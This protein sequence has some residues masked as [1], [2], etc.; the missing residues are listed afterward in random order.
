MTLTDVRLEH[1]TIIQH[2]DDIIS[3]WD[4]EDLVVDTILVLCSGFDVAREL[5]VEVCVR[6]GGARL[7]WRLDAGWWRFLLR[8]RW[9][10]DVCLPLHDNFLR[11]LNDGLIIMNAA[12]VD[13]DSDFRFLYCCEPS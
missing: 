13:C 3:G 2:P 4:V 8:R 10:L 6:G 9:L 5:S 7:R 12:S 11:E 1:H